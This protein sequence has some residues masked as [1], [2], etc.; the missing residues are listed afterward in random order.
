[1]KLTKDHFIEGRIIKKGTNISIINEAKQVGTSY[2][3]TKLKTLKAILTSNSLLA[4]RNTEMEISGIMYPYIS[5][6][7]DYNLSN[8]DSE[9]MPWGDIRISI[10][11]DSVSDKYRVV[12]FV[13]MRFLTSNDRKQ[14]RSES[15]NAI[16]TKELTN[17]SKY[18]LQIDMLEDAFFMLDVDYPELKNTLTRDTKN[19]RKFIQ[20]STGLVFQVVKN[21]LPYKY[22]K[23]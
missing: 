19:P 6:T 5:L 9:F 23:A 3:F 15:E 16:L 4:P 14:G 11:G 18:T 10:D 17:L 2:H 12:P 1:M 13:D 8:G 21:F 20:E 22:Q 7:R